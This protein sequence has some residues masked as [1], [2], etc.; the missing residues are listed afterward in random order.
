[1]LVEIAFREI[2]DRGSCCWGN[3]RLGKLADGEISVGKIT[4]HR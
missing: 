1:M 4:L 2:S 3:W